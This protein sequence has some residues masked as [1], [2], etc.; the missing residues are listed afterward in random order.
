MRLR[1]RAGIALALALAAPAAARRRRAPARSPGQRRGALDRGQEMRYITPHN[2]IGRP[3]KGYRDPSASSPAR[4]PTR[5]PRCRRRC[6]RGYTL[7][8]YDCYRPQRAVDDFV[9]WGKRLRDQRMKAEF[10]PRVDKRDVF[11]DGYI[12]DE[13]RPLPRQHGGPHARQAPARQAGALPPRR[14]AARLRRPAREA[15]PRQLDRHGHGLRLLRPARRTRST[16]RV[17][18]KQRAQPA[19]PAPRDARR[20]ASRGSRRSGG[21]SPCATSRSP[22]RSST[23]RSPRRPR[24]LTSAANSRS[25]S[26]AGSSVRPVCTAE[27]WTIV[28]DGA[29]DPVEALRLGHRRDVAALRAALGDRDERFELRAHLAGVA[30]RARARRAARRRARARAPR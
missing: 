14:P 6:A 5:S 10:Y 1:G 7:K 9:A 29:V 17:T 18:E 23:S 30:A 26:P 25:S 24:R 16:P 11:K 27:G 19:D 4:P 20:R 8:V 2:F 15:V 13:V 12:A 28:L 22:R 3:I 21:T